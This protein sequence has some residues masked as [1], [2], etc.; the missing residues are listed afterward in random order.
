[1]NR[2][3]PLIIAGLTIP[4]LAVAEDWNAF[5]GPRGDG[6]STEK[7][8]PIRWGPNENIIWKVKLPRPGNGS[9]IVSKGR[10]FV[11][12]AEDADGK[13]RSLYCFDRKDGKQL[14][15]RTVH[16]PHKMPTHNTNP[17]CAPTP[18]ADGQRVV[19]WHGSA[20]LYCYDFEGNELWKKD[21]GE[22]RHMWG[23]ASSSVI[24]G[25]R[26]IQYCGPGERIFVTAI[27]L[28]TGKTIWETEEPQQG[29]GERN[30]DGKYM[31]SWGTP[32]IAT[33]DGKE[34]I[35]CS[36]PTR[37]VAYDPA[38]GD[39]L[40]YCEGLRGQRGDLAY[41][42]PM[43]ADKLCVAI[44]GFSGPGLGL[45]LGGT[46][47]LTATNRLWRNESNPQ[48]IGT[49]I[50]LGQHVFRANATVNGID[51]IDATTGKVI[52]SNR[53]AGSNWG[54]VVLAGGNLYVTA[55]NGTTVVYK[56]N[57]KEAEIIA[58][59][60]LGERTNSTPA[61]SDGQIFL[62]TFEH[63]YCIGENTR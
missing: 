18:A 47:N 13:E 30:T 52:W 25:D 41:S 31:G 6:I 50:F 36:M 21:L 14:W 61:I 32:V 23:Y 35:L 60:R 26:V 28:A 43:I 62:R 34:Q 54:S 57:P 10:V 55:Q 5:R 22:F 46:G 53:G 15:V 24:H 3:L 42:S 19:V 56:P 29:N 1:M 37:L 17:Y 4:A 63:L 7:N 11:T 40:W 12:C 49:G 44:G 51:C 8:V 39:I 16:Y 45:K 59:N 48:S 58:E 2:L 27:D 20:G 9:P 33:V 38:N